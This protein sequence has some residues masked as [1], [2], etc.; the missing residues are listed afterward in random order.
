MIIIYMRALY[1]KLKIKTVP[2]IL[3][4]NKWK[5]RTF[6]L[7]SHVILIHKNFVSIIKILFTRRYVCESFQRQ[8]S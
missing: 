8:F 1:E 7:Y 3:Y 4:I 5:Y 6:A 2:P